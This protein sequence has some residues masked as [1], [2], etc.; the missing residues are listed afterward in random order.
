MDFDTL[1]IRLEHTR[2]MDGPRII[3]LDGLEQFSTE[4]K[5]RQDSSEDSIYDPVFCDTNLRKAWR[6]ACIRLDLGR[7]ESLPDGKEIYRGL[8]VQD[9]RRSAVRNMIDAGVDKRVAMKISG[10]KRREVLDPYSTMSARQV[11]EAMVKVRER[12]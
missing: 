5:V 12:F 3:L 4:L 6:R 2:S 9:L 1:E 7:M 11:H 10:Y 8:L